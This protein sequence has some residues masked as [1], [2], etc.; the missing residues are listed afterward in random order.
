MS[1]IGRASV[2]FQDASKRKEKKTDRANI[3]CQLRSRETRLLIDESKRFIIGQR[4]FKPSGALFPDEIPSFR[5]RI[6]TGM[7]INDIRWMVVSCI[8]V[9]WA[10]DWDGG[11]RRR[12]HSVI[13]HSYLFFFF[14]YELRWQWSTEPL[15]FLFFFF[16]WI[17]LINAPLAFALSVWQQQ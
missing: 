12:W 3:A 6:A 10:G 15:L 4:R 16:F 13:I 11:R 8:A 2:S 9:E 1:G 14:F 5:S 17:D 7:N